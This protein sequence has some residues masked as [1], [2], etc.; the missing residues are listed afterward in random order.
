M[1]RLTL[2]EFVW[3]NWQD[4]WSIDLLDNIP[5]QDR[6]LVQRFWGWDAYRPHTIRK[7]AKYTNLPPSTVHWRIKN[8]LRKMKEEIMKRRRNGEAVKETKRNSFTIPIIKKEE[9]RVRSVLWWKELRQ[10]V[11]KRDKGECVKCGSYDNLEVHHINPLCS[12]GTN[13]TNNLITLCKKCHKEIQRLD[14]E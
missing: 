13:K 12:G 8:V 3:E 4:Q 14:K 5:P 9:R 1:I 10:R 11:I 7:I 6:D 2:E